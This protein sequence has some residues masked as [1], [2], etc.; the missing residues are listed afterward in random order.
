MRFQAIKLIELNFIKKV[1]FFDERLSLRRRKK[2]RFR[3]H[4]LR[5]TFGTRLG[6]AGQDL[7]AIMEIIGHKNPK[8]A[9]RYQHPAPEHKL[10]A[11]QIIDRCLNK[12]SPARIV[13]FKNK[14]S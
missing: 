8:T 3:F 14:L 2:V 4:D 6:M 10:Q 12:N 7:K 9:M 1:I 13:E 11:V 5:H